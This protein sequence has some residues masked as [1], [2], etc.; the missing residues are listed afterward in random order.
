MIVLYFVSF[1][2]EFGKNGLNIKE[3]G[4]IKN[5]ANCVLGFLFLLY[6]WIS[7]IHRFDIFLFKDSIGIVFCDSQNRQGLLLSLESS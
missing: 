5:T 2:Y 1:L 3:F 7:R 6:F 4:K